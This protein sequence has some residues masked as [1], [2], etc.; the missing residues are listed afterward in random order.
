MGD[1]VIANSIQSKNVI[2]WVYVRYGALVS[3]TKLLGQKS[4]CNPA[5]SICKDVGKAHT[6]LEGQEV[7][8]LNIYISYIKNSDS[9]LSTES[10]VD[11]T[12]LKHKTQRRLSLRTSDQIIT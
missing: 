11:I 8:I 12:N 1:S 2:H 10:P 9:T 5:Y 6:S 4:N 7:N 3:P